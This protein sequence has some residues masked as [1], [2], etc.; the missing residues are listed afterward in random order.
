MQRIFPHFES[1]LLKRNVSTLHLVGFAGKARSEGNPRQFKPETHPFGPT[2]AAPSFLPD[3]N[4]TTKHTLKCPCQISL[5]SFYASIL[6]FVF[7]WSLWPICKTIASYIW[8]QILQSRQFYG[9]VT[10]TLFSC[11]SLLEH[12]I[13]VDH[14]ASGK[15]ISNLLMAQFSRPNAPLSWSLNANEQGRL[16]ICL[17]PSTC[18]QRSTQSFH[19]R[20]SSFSL[21]S[22]DF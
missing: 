12:S 10:Q 7:D 19:I 4:L 6:L 14:K 5:L 13:I 18:C 21:N 20:R 8:T 17:H 15:Y 16:F 3:F 2:T 11:A 9:G 1:L 22:D